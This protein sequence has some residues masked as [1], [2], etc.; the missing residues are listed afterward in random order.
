MLCDHCH[1]KEAVMRYTVVSEGRSQD[2]H[3]C[4]DCAAEK[5]LAGQLGAAISSLSYLLEDLFKDLLKQEGAE[6]TQACAGCGLDLEGFRQRGRLGC[7]G[8]YQAFA[9]LLRRMIRQIHGSSRHLGKIKVDRPAPEPPAED[10]EALR[11]RMAEAV[12][13]EEFELAASLRDR[14]KILEAKGDG[15]AV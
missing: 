9:P 12:K 14:I 11:R 4:A 13:K 6:S 15:P 8:C 7:D 10:I 5:G 2:Y 3:L 1:N